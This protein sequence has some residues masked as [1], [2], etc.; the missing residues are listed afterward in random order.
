MEFTFGVYISM[1]K[2]YIV[3]LYMQRSKVNI[4]FVRLNGNLVY[5]FCQF[6]SFSMISVIRFIFSM[7]GM[8][9]YVFSD[10]INQIYM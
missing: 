10:L 2:N 5:T 6:I 9:S 8:C 7:N 3:R 4:F 1:D